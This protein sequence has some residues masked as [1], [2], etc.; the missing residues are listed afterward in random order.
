MGARTS[1]LGCLAGPLQV[2]GQT[3]R[4]K[5]LAIRMRRIAVYFTLFGALPYSGKLA[6]RR[7]GFDTATSSAS[8]GPWGN[9][10]AS[11]CRGF[12]YLRNSPNAENDLWPPFPTSRRSASRDPRRR[13]RSPSAITTK[14]S[15]RRQEHEGPFS[16][17]GSP[18]GTP[19]AA[20]GPIRLAPARRCALGKPPRTTWRMP[21]TA[22]VWH[23]S[24][25]A[26]SARRSIASTTGT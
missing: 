8:G 15:G 21:S 10:L 3:P 20:R 19:S 18:T 9:F 13:T 16:A 1:D 14:R 6:F 22:R 25:S 26:S 2:C 23:S 11:N 24:S 7:S 17:S 5:P 4:P 12:L